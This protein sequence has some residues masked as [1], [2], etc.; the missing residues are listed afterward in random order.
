MSIKYIMP[1]KQNKKSTTAV[2]DMLE[3]LRLDTL[4]ARG[5]SDPRKE[6][7]IMDRTSPVQAKPLEVFPGKSETQVQTEPL[8]RT[9]S[10]YY[11][12]PDEPEP[13][14]IRHPTRVSPVQSVISES[15]ASTGRMLACVC[16]CEQCGTLMEVSIILGIQPITNSQGELLTQE[17]ENRG[18][19]MKSAKRGN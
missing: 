18:F 3:K 10:V 16:E 19:H 5:L 4:K 15:Q 12:D 17:L 6:T 8:E 11:Y 13:E 1:P 2:S 14:L 7:G 9:D